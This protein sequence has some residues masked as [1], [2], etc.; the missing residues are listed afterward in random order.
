M[1]IFALAPLFERRY[2]DIP[3]H[4][5]P[6]AENEAI[7]RQATANAEATWKR[8]SFSLDQQRASLG[9]SDSQLLAFNDL[10]INEPPPFVF[11][12]DDSTVS[13]T[14]KNGLLTLCKTPSNLIGPKS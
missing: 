9:R 7:L 2:S 4:R 1:F 12:D 3:V 5:T 10:S 13:N 14:E 6:S 8:T 11:L